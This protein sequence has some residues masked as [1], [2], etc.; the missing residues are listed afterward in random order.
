MSKS[1]GMI[2]PKAE[3][4]LSDRQLRLNEINRAALP[5]V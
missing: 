2:L 5:L 1:N 4:K 3:C